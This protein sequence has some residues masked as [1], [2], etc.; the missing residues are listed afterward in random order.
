M[1]NNIEKRLEKLEEYTPEGPDN[2]TALLMK[3]GGFTAKDFGDNP[4]AQEVLDRLRESRG[5]G[6]RR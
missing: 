2:Y 6:K 3:L 1:G 4:T 5:I